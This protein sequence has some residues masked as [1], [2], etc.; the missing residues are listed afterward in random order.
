MGSECAQVEVEEGGHIDAVCAA[1]VFVVVDAVNEQM[2]GVQLHMAFDAF[3]VGVPC[4]Y[5]SGILL[6]LLVFAVHRFQVFAVVAHVLFGVLL[7]GF[8]G[9]HAHVLLAEAGGEEIGVQAVLHLLVRRL[10]SVRKVNDK[11]ACRLGGITEEMG[12]FV[13]LYAVELQRSGVF[14][15]GVTT[16]KEKSRLPQA[17][18]QVG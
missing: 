16:G 1:G 10:G 7:Y 4:P 8:F 5:L 9:S 11:V 15:H 2:P 12:G 6:V 14:V 13:H 17:E 18:G 3:I